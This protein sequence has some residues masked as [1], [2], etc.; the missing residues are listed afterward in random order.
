MQSAK[1]P[2]RLVTNETSRPINK[3]LGTLNM[4]GYEVTEQDLISP[5][6]AVIK[7]LKDGNLRPFLMIHPEVTHNVILTKF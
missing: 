4:L 2:F 6:P 5:V 1:I 3:I 7:I